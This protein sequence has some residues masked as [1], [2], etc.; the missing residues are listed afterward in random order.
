MDSGKVTKSGDSRVVRVFISSTFRDFVEERNLLAKDV[1]PEL[2]RRARERFVEVQEV[3]L[4]W[5]ITQDQSDRGETL[6][7]CLREIERARPYFI[8]FLGERYGW[9]P[10]KGQHPELLMD[11]QPWLHEH[12]GGTSVTELE[13]LHGV[14]R[15]PAMA[16]RAC[17]YFRDPKWSAGR[18]ADFR[19]EGEEERSKLER[20]KLRIRESAFPVVEYETPEEVAK[21]IIDDLWKVIDEQYPADALPDELERTRR[22]HESYAFERCRGYVGQ[23][24]AVEELLSRLESA[25]DEAG[26]DGARSRMTVV[27]GE[28]GTGKSALIANVMAK[29]RANHRND[30]VIEHY[31]AAGE[32][33]ARPAGI[34]R[35]LAE[36]IKRATGSIKEI[37]S[38]D[39]VLLQQ[40]AE[41]FA[42]AS[43]WAKR[44]GKS[45]IIVLDGLDK[46]KSGKSLGW[47]PQKMAPHLRVVVST[48]SGESFDELRQ[49]GVVELAAQPFTK[50][51]AREYL[52]EALVTRRGRQLPAREI[53]RIID[54]PRATLPIFLKTLVDELCV[55][56][57]FE[58]L[59]DRISE[60]LA[61][62]KPSDLFGVIL[63]RLEGDLG[64][65]IVQKPLEAIWAS[66]G[67]MSDSELVDFAKITP[68]QLARIKLTL[69]DALY[70]DRGMV[71]FAHAYVRRGV[72]ERYEL[73]P[74]RQR[75][76]HHA[77]GLWWSEQPPSV[78]MGLGVNLHLY[79]AEAW[80]DLER[81][82]IDV[83]VGGAILQGFS[84][85]NLF[86]SWSKVAEARG[87]SST[88]QY[89][90]RA[91]GQA[92]WEWKVVDGD[93]A[94]QL[95]IA[96]RLTDLLSTAEAFDLGLEVSRHGLELARAIHAEL[97]TPE[98]RR[99]V[100]AILLRSAN[101]E[102]RRGDLE[103]ALAKYNECLEIARALWEALKTPE[104][105]RD[106]SVTLGR[107][108]DIEVQ[109]GDLDAAMVKY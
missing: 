25:N 46:L 45:V 50:E 5:G 96:G 21:R 66:F 3:D 15:D 31:L 40:L 95:I 38:K 84:A 35:R 30:V 70:G 100:S 14:L 77:L 94:T 104:S 17:F 65:E 55:Y 109:R 51:T 57:S 107:I 108:A 39:D 102:F 71:N 29:Y 56:G 98:S 88:G 2:R 105:L 43:A 61:A 83:G 67:R 7:V 68:Y 89:L 42:E 36:E 34:L 80:D 63:E 33:S 82:L 32:G 79:R 90:G 85:R 27:T 101:I 60:C 9:T 20:L 37:E 87:E 12:A 53:E 47:L 64:R 92:W 19:S 62:E 22:S 69:T 8:G 54:H 75:S 16:G 24:R 41:W 6:P 4:R 26:S 59:S 97:K 93:R 52:G 11:Q 73:T 58:G 86:R 10:S 23:E 78:R 99:A 74:E 81:C 76:T 48:L 13:I 28:S 72:R 103:A 49:R 106:V 91:M 44:Q 18:G 1:F